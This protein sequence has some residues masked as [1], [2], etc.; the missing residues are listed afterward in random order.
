M[1]TRSS[2]ISISHVLRLI[3][4]TFP[5]NSIRIIF[6]I[7]DLDAEQ[8]ADSEAYLEEEGADAG[9]EEGGS[10]DES[11]IIETAILITKPGGGALAI[12]AVARGAFGSSASCGV[13]R[14]GCALRELEIRVTGGS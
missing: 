4:V 12:D 1:A 10:S 5:L 13:R 14:G 6:S 7:S 9:D 8:E 2:S 3:L 11:F